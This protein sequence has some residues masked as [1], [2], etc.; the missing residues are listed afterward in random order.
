[1]TEHFA[2]FEKIVDFAILDNELSQENDELTPT[3]K[4]R[5]E[6]IAKRYEKIIEKMYN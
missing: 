3:L 4:L 6:V 2:D 1:M 5:R